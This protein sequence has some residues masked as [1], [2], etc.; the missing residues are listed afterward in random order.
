M[1]DKK[2]YKLLKKLSKVPFLTYSEINGVLKTN[3]NFEHE[4]NEYTQHL[5]TLGYIQPHSSGV[6]GD[7]NSDIYDGYEINLNG[8]GYVDDKQEKFWQFLIPYCITTLVAIIALCV[9]A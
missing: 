9:A 6:K 8:Q 5:C 4:I 7:F 3:T 2:S 1:L